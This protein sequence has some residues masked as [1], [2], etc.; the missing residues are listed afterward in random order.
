MKNCP[1][2]G[3]PMMRGWCPK[4]HPNPDQMGAYKWWAVGTALQQVGCLIMLVVFVI[5][6]CIVLLWA[7][8]TS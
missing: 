4:C 6:P 1:N 7:C 2:C 8:A 3:T 5:I